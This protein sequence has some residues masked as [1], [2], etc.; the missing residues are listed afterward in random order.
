MLS[1]VPVGNVWLQKP[2]IKL[3][4]RPCNVAERF[5]KW[6]NWCTRKYFATLQK[7]CKQVARQCCNILA[8][9]PKCVYVRRP[10][11]RSPK[12]SNW[13]LFTTLQNTSFC[14]QKAPFG[15][16]MRTCEGDLS[17]W[18]QSELLA[19]F[20]FEKISKYRK[21][22]EEILKHKLPKAHYA[23]KMQGHLRKFAERFQ[24]QCFWCKRKC[25]AMLQ[26]G[27]DR[28]LLVTF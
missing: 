13:N 17:N 20:C 4:L 5:Q 1:L 28:N 7:G 26:N 12:G 8:K 15:A 25:F 22:I 11:R 18:L 16:F 24:T 23:T 19:M 6:C 9:R 10:P 2:C 21:N 14:T 3:T 27:F